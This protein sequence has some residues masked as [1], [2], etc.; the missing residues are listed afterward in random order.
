MSYAGFDASK[1]NPDQTGTQFA[2]STRE[3]MLFLRDAVR[4]GTMPLWDLATTGT[5]GQPSAIT[6][7]KADERL[8]VS[9]T[10]GSS[11]AT[12]GA[13]TQAVYEYSD[14]AGTDWDAIGTE[15]I[16]YDGS[17]NVTAINWS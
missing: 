1:P 3:N 2:N 14:N 11:G 8:R 15:T 17:G 6:Y 13:V 7:S 5:S 9:L 10:Y 4:L 12:D 16:T